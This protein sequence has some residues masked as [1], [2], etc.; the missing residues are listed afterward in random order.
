MTINEMEVY[1]PVLDLLGCVKRRAKISKVAEEL[2][3]NE[4]TEITDKNER[5]SDSEETNSINNDIVDESVGGKFRIDDI[6]I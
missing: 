3:D 1:C 6:I 2:D 4:E 5:V